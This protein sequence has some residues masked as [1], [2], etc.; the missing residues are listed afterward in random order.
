MQTRQLPSSTSTGPRH[1][2][3]KFL[4]L[5]IGDGYLPDIQHILRH[6]LAYTTHLNSKL[7]LM[8]FTQGSATQSINLYGTVGIG[9][10]PTAYTLQV[11]GTIG[12]SGDITAL[13]SDDRLK[14]R[15]ESLE[16]ALEK[17]CSLDTFTYVSNDLAKSLGYDDRKR[18]GLSAQQVQKI[19]PEAVCPAPADPEYLTIQYEKLVPLLV[20]AI[21][22]LS[23]KTKNG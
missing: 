23:V 6:H 19:V 3:R 13:Y 14:I 16:N 18:V 12:A 7:K 20:E 5:T 4:Q 10:A 9:T 22:E 2:P 8:S 17:V 21:K 1:K 11:G 15:L